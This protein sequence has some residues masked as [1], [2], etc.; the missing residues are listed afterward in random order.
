M[1]LDY[2]K[3]YE[4]QVQNELRCYEQG[5]H[6]YLQ[7][8][9]EAGENIE[10]DKTLVSWINKHMKLMTQGIID[11]LEHE[12]VAHPT[13]KSK[14][15]M[16]CKETL[17]D[18]LAYYTLRY[19]VCPD[20]IL[21]EPSVVKVSL[22]LGGYLE[23]SMN[24]HKLRL[25]HHRL[26]DVK[27]GL[28][29]K[30]GRVWSSKQS[31]KDKG[32]PHYDLSKADKAKAGMWLMDIV[33][34]I[35]PY[36]ELKTVKTG[37]GKHEKTVVRTLDTLLNWID[38]ADNYLARTA[39]LREPM[40]H[41]PIPW[42]SSRSGGYL[43]ST[44]LDRKNSTL[45]RTFNKQYLKTLDSM[46]IS[47]FLDSLNAVQ[48]T[49]WMINKEVLDVMNWCWDE[50]IPLG[51]EGKELMPRYE[52]VV[53]PD[54]PEG[55]TY[56]SYKEQ[57][58]EDFVK[59]MAFR[60]TTF[61]ENMRNRSKRFLAKYCLGLADRYKDYEAIW[62]PH[63]ADFR[64]RLYPIPVMLN[65]QGSDLSKG[66]LQF[67]EGKKLGEDGA[68]WLH[69]H[70]ANC[71]GVDKVSNE[72]RVEWTQRNMDAI[73][74]SAMNPKD[75][76]GFWMEADKPV[77]ALAVA[78]ELLKYQV[79]GDELVSHLP[80]YMDGTCNGLQHFSAMLRDEV[81]AKATNL[82]PQ[83]KPNDIYAQVADIVKEKSETAA[84]QGDLWANAWVPIITRSTVKQPV[85]TLPYGATLRGM[86]G[87]L[88]EWLKKNN[89]ML[90]TYTDTLRA[91]NWLAKTTYD[92]IGEVVKAAIDAMNYL[93]GVA[94]V[95]AK[96]DKPV[97]WM[98]PIG[99]PVLQYYMRFDSKRIMATIKGR[100]IRV[101]I[102]TDNFILDRGRQGQGIA[103]NF[104]HARDSSHLLMTVLLAKQQDINSFAMVH[105]S[106]GTHACDT[107]TLHACIRDSFVDMYS[108]NVLQEFH[109]NI[110]KQLEDEQIA[111]LPEPPMLGNLDLETVRDSEYF[112]N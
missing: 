21:N 64:A 32:L 72:E 37:Y 38:E 78:F 53:P 81:G 76:M 65:P 30:G 43:K 73:L 44:Y 112:F 92:S 1:K 47:R 90:F 104:V 60:A 70:A 82:I 68:Y 27:Q 106:Y 89:P 84:H 2:D 62:F 40:V 23:E 11:K 48:A 12:K 63:N 59:L 103:P 24:Y 16:L 29:K 83:E 100:N 35:F 74:D 95:L 75:G 46:D 18:E 91:C 86:S 33:L 55:F 50:R 58:P 98:T 45:V 9:L 88:E 54:I 20:M 101:S 85:M 105:D 10:R 42:T 69:V 31:L 17:P 7:K 6:E 19:F 97:S 36:W 94:R 4:E 13:R 79:H 108:P 28:D 25:E 107:S 71:W 56:D 102:S 3:L 8:R 5:R 41:P 52:P 109:E 57:H 77:S 87:Q 67:A 34:S 96:L 49:P 61:K 99:F 26:N 80:I 93:Q 39:A 110:K 14:G 15:Y 22:S 51:S 111:M 66:L